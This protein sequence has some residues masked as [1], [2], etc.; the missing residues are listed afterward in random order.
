LGTPP[1]APFL[2]EL[3]DRSSWIGTVQR[4]EIGILRT[5][6]RTD[7]RFVH[8][9]ADRRPAPRI[10]DGADRHLLRRTKLA[11]HEVTGRREVADRIR[12]RHLPIRHFGKDLLRHFRQLLRHFHKPQ[13]SIGAALRLTLSIQCTADGIFH[14]GLA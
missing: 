6:A 4:D 10:V 1:G 8:P 2:A 11:Y 14:V 3:G 7:G 12:G 5:T 13:L 9:G